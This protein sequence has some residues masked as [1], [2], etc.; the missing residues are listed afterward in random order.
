MGVINM[1]MVVI[2]FH[3]LLKGIDTTYDINHF[4]LNDLNNYEI[5]EKIVDFI[6]NFRLIVYHPKAMELES[7]NKILD[8]L[9]DKLVKFHTLTDEIP[10][11]TGYRRVYNLIKIKESTFLIREIRKG[12]ML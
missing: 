1:D 9:I 10:E 5:D 12:D 4:S 7:R 11:S 8:Y 2:D 3:C 6:N